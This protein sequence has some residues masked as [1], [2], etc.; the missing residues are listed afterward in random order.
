MRNILLLQYFLRYTSHVTCFSCCHV[1]DLRSVKTPLVGY[2]FLLFCRLW[3]I[4]FSLVWRGDLG[5]ERRSEFLIY[6]KMSLLPQA[7]MS[8]HGLRRQSFTRTLTLHT[9]RSS[10]ESA[11]RNL[12]LTHTHTH[13]HRVYQKSRQSSNYP[14]KPTQ[15]RTMMQAEFR[16]ALSIVH[17]GDPHCF[18]SQSCGVLKGCAYSLL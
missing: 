14:Y 4:L 17:K 8:H 1:S 12:S 9:T 3:L 10:N 15:L 18:S 5:S 7:V 11:A 2:P 16:G 6:W 13:T